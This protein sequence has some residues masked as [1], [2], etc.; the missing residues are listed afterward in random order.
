MQ[1]NNT[2]KQ[3][4]AGAECADVKS[5]DN[6]SRFLRLLDKMP[7]P[8]ALLSCFALVGM[9]LTWIIPAGEYERVL[10]S[11]NNVKMIVSGS[12]QYLETNNPQGIIEF[13]F[14][15]W[16]G[17]FASNSF[18]VYM[19]LIGGAIGA[20]SAT[21]AIDALIYKAHNFSEKHPGWDKIIVSCFIIFFGFC[22]STFGLSAETLIFLP[23]LVALCRTFNYDAIVAVALSIAA[24]NLGYACGTTNAFNI[25]LAQGIAELPLMSGIGFRFVWAI[26]SF[27]VSIWY[28]LRYCKRIQCNP[29]ASLVYDI[30]YSDYSV[31]DAKQTVEMTTARLLSLITFLLA[32]SGVV[33]GAIFLQ[34]GFK[35]L[36]TL[37]L[38][39]A[40]ICGIVS[41]MRISDFAESFAKGAAT[42]VV[43]LM[44]L[45]V[46][47]SFLM[48]MQDGMI[49]DTI[50]HFLAQPLDM[51][52]RSLT[53]AAMVIFQGLLN[54]F[55]P[56]A[57]GQAAVSMPIM[58]P[59]A[60][61]LEINRQVAVF[62]FQIG[63][64]FG[65]VV[66]P[67]FGP[68]MAALAI[69]RVPYGRWFA[70]AAPLV[71][72][73]Y[74]LGIIATIIANFIDYGPF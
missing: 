43:P 52:P 24:C 61:L 58:I 12:F 33:Y 8:L 26:F 38:T 23:I 2:H 60:D 49:M 51:L 42:M 47:R 68:L 73:Q 29:A 62:A 10:N 71:L 72:I 66:I 25:G 32:I 48:I 13:L 41:R 50:I 6:G 45:G 39:A 64:G 21:G 53:V 36:S 40:F 3:D 31:V 4:A 74:G 27:T 34:F 44:L 7:H 20:I 35:Q 69:A 55:I 5:F 67:T 19:L 17:M 14:S 57:S 70:F 30:D 56:A 11:T 37:F 9:V 65:N 28:V 59:L 46:A 18:T 22:G 15:F 54:I 63:D 16:N 1:K